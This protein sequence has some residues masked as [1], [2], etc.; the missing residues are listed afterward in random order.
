ML[1]ESGQLV[2][3]EDIN[4]NL[5]IIRLKKSNVFILAILMSLVGLFC[6]AQ[7]TAEEKE[8]IDVAINIS[9]ELY[10]GNYAYYD[11][12]FY[13]DSFLNRV[14]IDD[15]ALMKINKEF[16]NGF[17]STFSFASILGEEVKAGGLYEP[18]SFTTLGNSFY[19]TF[20]QFTNK[21]LNYH[22]VE[23]KRIKD[24]FR[25]VDVFVYLNGENLS[26]T[27]KLIYVGV[28][29]KGNVLDQLMGRNQAYLKDVSAL[30]DFQTLATAG[31]F[32]ELN[33]YLEKTTDGFKQT[34]FY[35]NLK[36]QAL[37]GLGD[38]DGYY[39]FLKN[40]SSI[41]IPSSFLTSIDLLFL[42]KDWEGFQ[43]NLNLLDEFVG[44][45]PALNNFR[46]NGYLYAGDYLSAKKHFQMVYDDFPDY[47]YGI[48]GILSTGLEQGDA[49][50]SVNAMA[51]LYDR[52]GFTL[53]DLENIVATYP[54]IKESTEFQEYIGSLK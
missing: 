16:N 36:I 41:G 10:K 5:K 14:N 18:V 23:F 49:K 7:D 42:E 26:E 46:G 30:L 9:N 35:Y 17:K 47:S 45:D 28:V 3:E 22:E 2:E 43:T 6:N 25:I 52:F 27:V 53:T 37:S 33:Q 19:V 38:T 1:W 21:G 50:T 13:L 24:K 34:K 8:L 12:L 32:K 31:K 4:P 20:S 54:V 39:A 51:D 11:E 44:G 48:I 29:D 40:N 15:P